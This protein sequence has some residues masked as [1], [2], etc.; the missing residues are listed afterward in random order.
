MIKNIIKR[1][2]KIEAFDAS[3]LNGWGEW[4]SRTLGKSVVWGDVVINAV[5]TLEE[6]TTS[7]A[8]QDALIDTCLSRRTWAYNRMAGRLYASTLY[9]HAFN[10]DKDMIL[11]DK[12]ALP[13][14][15]DLHKSMV[16][17]DILSSTF[18]DSFSDEEYEEINGM[19]SHS[20]DMTYPHY[21]IK[22]IISKYS[23]KDRT[24]DEVRE[25]PQYVY[26]RVAMRM[27]QNKSNRLHHI[28]RLYYFYSRNKINIP[29]PY[30]T[31]SG[32]GKNGFN[33]CCVYKTDDTVRSLAAGDHIAYVMTYSSAGIGAAIQTRSEGSPIRGGI[34]E[35]RGKNSYYKSLVGAINA[36]M[37]NGRGGA[38]TVTYECFDPDV[39]QIQT[40]KHPLTP[41]SKQIRGIDYS[42]AFNIFFVSKASKNEE[43]ALFSR[44]NAQ[45]VYD[46]ITNPISRINEFED[47]YNA[48]LKAGKAVSF[49]NAREILMGALNQAIETGRHYYTN[50]TEINTHT[51]FKE[52]IHQSNLCQEIMLPTK[53]Y[54]S[55][56]DLYATDDSVSGE[57]GMCSLAAIVV[58]NITSD[59]EYAEA[60]Y[61]ALLMIHTAIHEA[62]YELPHLSF[63]ARARNSA[64]VGLI[65]VAHWMAKNKLQYDSEEGKH[66]LHKMAET[67]Y[68]HLL[69]ASIKMS[70][71]YGIA[72]WMDKTNWPDGWLPLDT[73]NKNIDSIADFKNE[74]DWEGI[75]KVIISNG[76]IH[77]SVLVAHMPTESSSISSGTTNGIY[78]IRGTA[79]NKSNDDD[80][81]AWLA[82]DSDKL[83]KYYQNAYL[84]PSIDM[85]QDYGIFQ[86]WTD[87]G[88]SSDLWKVVIGTD[89]LSSTELLKDF[90]ATVKYGV[91]TRYY[92]NS[93]T[94]KDINLNDSE[95][96]NDIEINETL[97]E[98]DC[99]GCTI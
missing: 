88:I 79:L 59:E 50:L 73:Y 44:H 49:V 96:P 21:Q 58:S 74:R 65:G 31:N 86:K 43:V 40:L 36:N 84:I 95:D 80:T 89:K 57:V 91:K 55:T 28:K 60:A 7:V 33:S 47:A 76:G 66:A 39:A 45:E 87:Q 16:K 30:Y 46:N 68:W 3:K 5:S 34:I 69:N 1:N 72:K 11:T 20:L 93:K 25:T 85:I 52:A 75:R 10:S 70:E 94:S 29:T 38:A 48:A 17:A 2:G 4:A 98:A 27:A 23:L 12:T 99:E 9:K 14:I 63:T 18:V 41:A 8:L 82:P 15:Q 77:N 64:G 22:Q 53:G 35:H 61:Y 97:G 90:F 83:S 51:P 19:L 37:Q 81:I 54:E 6:N 71:E 24:T 42:M 62:D 56:K 92:I 78:P 26:M 32:T 67:H 13:T